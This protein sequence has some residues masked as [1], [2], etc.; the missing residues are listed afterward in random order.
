MSDD[1]KPVIWKTIPS[2]P[3]YEASSEGRIRR[4]GKT[5]LL[6][7]CP[8]SNGYLIYRLS[9][10]DGT[11]P[12]SC[13]HV[14][15]CEAFHGPRP[16]PNFDAAHDNGVKVDCREEN[17]QWKTKKANHADKRR[18]GKHREGEDISWSILKDHDIPV[19]LVRL[20]AGESMLVIAGDYGVSEGAI[21]GIRI[22][23]N[24]KHIKRTTL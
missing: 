2:F 10:G 22:D 17:L 7:L 23:R 21:N 8:G 15:V 13:G 12:S 20:A 1:A 4:I 6:A 16:G 11:F 3:L 9:K 5:K 18:H 24:W 19:I 14:L